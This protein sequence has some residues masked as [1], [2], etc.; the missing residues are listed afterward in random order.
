MLIWWCFCARAR[1][2]KKFPETSRDYLKGGNRTATA[3]QQSALLAGTSSAREAGLAHIGING[4][5]VFTHN[6]YFTNTA[7]GTYGEVPLDIETS[8]PV[9]SPSI[10]ANYSTLT[11]DL[12]FD[13]QGNAFI[14]E[15]L[16]GIL[17]RPANMTLTNNQTRLLIDLYG[18]NSNACGRTVRDK[19]ILHSTFDGPT[20]G[21]ARIDLAKAGVCKG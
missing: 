5:K 12:S 2:K 1:K 10:L 6:M 13:A 14:S 16:H 9:G 20:S 3:V 15:P 17:L 4:I 11:D 18:A 19:C 7:Q 8:Q 21:V